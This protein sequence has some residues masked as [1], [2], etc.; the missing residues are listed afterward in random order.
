[1]TRNLLFEVGAEVGVPV[2][3]AVLRES[4]LPAVDELFITSTTRE[5][6]PVVRVGDR[7]IGSG[8]PGPVAGRLLARLRERA[9]GLTRA[10]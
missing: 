9:E 3:E 8:A 5:I 7:T 6:V 2:R 10:G 1:M 4:D